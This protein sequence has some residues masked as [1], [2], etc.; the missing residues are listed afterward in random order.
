VKELGDAGISMWT[1][2]SSGGDESDEG[3]GKVGMSTGGDN[4]D[5]FRR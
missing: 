2:S 3:A 5:G 1:A 4:E